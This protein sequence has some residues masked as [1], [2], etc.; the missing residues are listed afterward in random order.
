MVDRPNSIDTYIGGESQTDGLEV[1]WLFPTDIYLNA[2]FGAYNKLGAE[3]DRM[4]NTV[5][6]RLSEFTYLGRLNTYLDIADNHS[7]ELGVTSAF[8]PR[9]VVA[10]VT[11]TVTTKNNTWRSLNGADLTYRYQPAR[12]G[13]YNG[14]L[15][16]T[17]IMQNKEQRFD[18]VTLRPTGRQTAYAGYTYIQLKAG[19]RWR[20]G[21][22]LDLTEDQDNP[23]KLTRTAEAFVQYDVTEFQALRLA[24]SYA[25]SNTSDPVNHT[26]M[27]QWTAVI[28]HHVHGFDMRSL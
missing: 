18:P 19:L 11:D 8:T 3:N 20:P 15:W 16:G 21:A 12:G 25:A 26:L 14:F 5:S 28:G 4:D 9:R 22:M 2:T 17:E 6:R 10:D 1:S 24:Y 27:L 7:V 23:H 13:L